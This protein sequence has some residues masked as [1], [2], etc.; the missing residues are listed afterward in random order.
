MFDV[1]FAELFLLV[2]GP[3]RLPRIAQKIG[4]VLRQA[5]QSWNV[6]KRTIE[7]EMAQS[8]LDESVKKAQ[9]NLRDIGSK[10]SDLPGALQDAASKA[11]A[12]AGAAGAGAGK[13]AEAEP[14]SDGEAPDPQTGTAESGDAVSAEATDAEG[15]GGD[16][17]PPEEESATVP[18]TAAADPAPGN[19]ATMPPVTSAVTPDET[20]EGDER[21]R[22]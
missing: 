8:G 14:A 12:A 2:L 15:A 17:A 22:E 11:G 1:G 4:S 5:R 6:M 7:A 20:G 3:E 19:P 21:T 18:G 16:E 10:V 9:E 13:P